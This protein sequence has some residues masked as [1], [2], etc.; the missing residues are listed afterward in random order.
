LLVWSLF[1]T[2]GAELAFTVY[3]GVYGV[4]NLI[5]HCLKLLSFYLM[6]KALVEVS[7]TQPYELLFRNLKTSEEQLRV[8]SE[9]LEEMVAERT[10]A[11]R[12]AQEQLVRR[13]KLAVMGQMAGSVGHELR[14]PLGAI[15]S[16]SYYLN[17]VLVDPEQDVAKVL[18][19]IDREAQSAAKITHDLLDFART[20]KARREAVSACELV[21]TAL[22]RASVPERV[23]VE[24]DIPSSLP[25]LWVDPEQIGRQVLVNLIVNAYQ[26]MPEGGDLVIG[27]QASSEERTRPA[28]VAIRVQDTGCGIAPKDLDKLFEPLFTTKARGIGLGL[29]VVKHLV[30]LNSGRIEV[31]STV[32]KGTTFTVYLPVAG[33]EG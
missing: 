5:G 15:M 16:A 17:Q 23:R 18:E 6:Y 27:A 12:E 4:P 33:E 20:N 32:G 30:D 22:G 1:L 2:I 3:V 7:L 19:I 8:Y 21:E 31:G 9:Q 10:E 14:N 11:L 13:E 28:A 24:V 29:A 25:E 26:A